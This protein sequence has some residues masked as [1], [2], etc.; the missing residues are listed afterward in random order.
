MYRDDM[1]RRRL[2]Q[3]GELTR[4]G[5][6]WW[7]RWHEDH[8]NADGE[9]KRGWSRRVCIGSCDG[10]GAFTK[11]QAQRTAWENFLSRLDQ[12]NRTPQSIMTVRQFVE[13]KFVPE[14]VV[15]LKRAGK[16]HYQSQLPFVLNG[17]PDKKGARGGKT[18]FKP[19]EEPP[20]LTRRFGIGDMRLRDVRRED[21]Q[22]LVGT[23]L[24]R[25]YSVQAAKHVK[26][27]ISAIYTHAQE[28]DWFSG[29]NPAQGVKLPE[30][31]RATPHALSFDQLSGL[32]SVLTAMVRIMVFM[33]SL[34]SMN[35][36]EICGLRWKRLNLTASPIIMDAELLPPFTAAVREQYYKGEYGS[37]KAK[38]RR[39]NVPLPVW[40]VT[41]LVELKKRDRSVGPEDPVF[42]GATGK[43]VCENAIVQ[44]HLKPAGEKLNM[45]WLSWHDLRRTFATLA[46]AEKISIGERK[47]LMGHARAEQTLAY[48]HTPNEQARSVLEALSDKLVKAAHLDTPKEQKVIPINKASGQ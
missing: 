17:V 16:D 12:N 4:A 21:A 9:C 29:K 10:L 23:M 20:A 1:A 42:A 43:P 45:P 40:L 33:A 46:D 28:E 30:M 36:A 35:I 32:L 18:R 15:Y 26:T 38:A 11:K 39:R 6:Y 41:A 31:V 3:N 8:I 48:T 24:D 44:R 47:E 37:E 34:T 5:G 22:R 14:H 19:G 7:L 27:V 13:R 25:G 2:Q